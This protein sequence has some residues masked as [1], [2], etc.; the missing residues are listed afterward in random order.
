MQKQKE[1]EENAMRRVGRGHIGH[2]V[3]PLFNRDDLDHRDLNG[4]PP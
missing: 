4:P 3:T 2:R 1:E